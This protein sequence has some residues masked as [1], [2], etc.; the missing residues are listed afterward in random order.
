MAKTV[1]STK[2]SGASG[3][4]SIN[5]TP[6]IDCTF[7]LIIFFILTA[8]FVSQQLPDMELPSLKEPKAEKRTGESSPNQITVNVLSA[9]ENPKAKQRTI[10]PGE[11]WMYQVG[12]KQVP[13]GN[14]SALT[15]LIRLRVNSAKSKGFRQKDI[16]VE[17]RADARVNYGAVAP[18]MMA[19]A[20]ANIEK[21]NITA[22]VT[23]QENQ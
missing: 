6:M 12:L 17:I 11:A 3:E 1:G 7:L 18:A 23:S 4:V 13:V 8:Q 22:K 16:F 19:A 9:H 15:D 21:M 2:R 20:K 5:L 10:L 14:I